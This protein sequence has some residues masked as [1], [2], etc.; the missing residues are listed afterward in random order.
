MPPSSALMMEAAR[1]SE[2][3]VHFYQTVWHYNPE[4]SHLRTHGCENLKSYCVLH[5]FTF[6]AWEKDRKEKEHKAG[7]GE[8]ISYLCHIKIWDSQLLFTTTSQ[9]R[10]TRYKYTTRI[11]E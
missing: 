5:Y 9:P 11:R 2:T 4:D 7:R 8:E 6:I 10:S 3:L 1:T